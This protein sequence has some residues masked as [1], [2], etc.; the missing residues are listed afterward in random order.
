MT[1]YAFLKV[2]NEIFKIM[3][4]TTTGSS[5]V[6]YVFSLPPFIF[7]HRVST[8]LFSCVMQIDEEYFES[9]VSKLYNTPCK[10]LKSF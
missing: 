3:N 4:N 9:P 6:G 10:I 2:D 5:Q 7:P 1:S 8:G